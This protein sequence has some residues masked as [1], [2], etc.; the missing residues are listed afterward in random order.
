M[1]Y[2]VGLDVSLKETSVCILDEMGAVCR[3]LK[4]LSHPEDLVRVLKDSALPFVRIGLEAGPMSS[5]S[6]PVTPRHS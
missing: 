4:A 6:R 5:A 1:R 2:Y 3:A